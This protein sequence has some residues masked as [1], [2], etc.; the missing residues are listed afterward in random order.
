MT[1][2]AQR[3]RLPHQAAPARA[4]ERLVIN[5]EATLAHVGTFLLGLWYPLGSGVA[6]STTIGDLLL[7]V[8]M[9]VWWLGL[10]RAYGGTTLLAVGGLTMA[11][12]LL[13]TEFSKYDHKVS[14]GIAA[15]ALMLLFGVIA[16]AGFVLWARDSVSV[17][18]LGLVYGV[19]LLV[20][21]G[22][23]GQLAFNSYAWKNGLGIGTAVVVL[24]A[25]LLTRSAA[26]R[27]VAEVAGLGAL[28]LLSVL[29]DSRS[30]LATFLLTFALV[31]WQR[32]P[33]RAAGRRSWAWV[34]GFI[35][36]LAIGMYQ[37]GTSLLV[38]GYLGRDAQAR[39]VAQ[40]RQAGSLIL[41][42]RPE[43]GATIALFKYRF[44]GFGAGVIA[45]S[46]DVRAAKIGLAKL[47]YDPNNGYVDQFMFGGQIELHST[48]GDLWAHFG[49][50]GIAMCLLFGYLVFR[51]LASAVAD[52]T[53]S[54]L[55]FFLCWWSLW[56]VFFSPFLSAAP[57]ML[58]ALGFAM[59]KKLRDPT[60][61][62]AG[63]S[64]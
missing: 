31:L 29:L 7:L 28:S 42:G 41:G 48:L 4:S 9:P 49:L 63:S 56:N 8:C 55:V 26:A 34:A 23:F 51:G 17:P 20:Q 27:L 21:A 11:S 44:T 13:L 43:L 61:A 14:F 33:V 52:R 50:T 60:A 64:P 2:P 24:S 30:Y 54:A 5:R 46:A 47:N 1:V 12:G 25:A 62:V 19:G 38:N 32:R 45:N 16:G 22:L 35:A 53:G 58:P 59:A 3:Q 57:I 39:T 37:L 18:R 6:S 40:I 10:R 15:D 36:A